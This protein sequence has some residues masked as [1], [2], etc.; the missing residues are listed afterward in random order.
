MKQ[1]RKASGKVLVGSSDKENYVGAC[2]QQRTATDGSSSD[3]KRRNVG[4]A[5][6][7]INARASDPCDTDV[8]SGGVAKNG[9]GV[10]TSSVA[11]KPRSVRRLSEGNWLGALAAS[12]G[13][14]RD[15][16]TSADETE[17]A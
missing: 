17:E 11:L 10:H 3:E 5:K 16:H 4:R 9:A 15:D 14:S 13:R 7:S 8:L 2:G 1:A 12:V 6:E